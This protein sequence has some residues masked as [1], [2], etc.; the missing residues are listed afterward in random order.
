MSFVADILHAAM[1]SQSPATEDLAAVRAAA[2]RRLR[3]AG[4]QP[5]LHPSRG[6]GTLRRGDEALLA[7]FL[8]GEATAFDELCDR[9]LARLVGHARRH[10]PRPADAEDLVHETFLV[11]LRRGPEVLQHERPNVQAFL[12]GTLRKKILKAWSARTFDELGDVPEEVDLT[13]ILG[14]QAQ[15]KEILRLI[16]RVCNLRE[17]QVL[18]M[19]LDGFKNTEIAAELEIRAGH[20]AKLKFDALRKLR[21]AQESAA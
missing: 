10:A 18:A 16:E 5:S 12:F 20:V 2:Y 14:E 15:R 19:T 21:A 17:Q 13:D 3:G 9:H 7:D 6:G 8:S 1:T 4:W 11:L